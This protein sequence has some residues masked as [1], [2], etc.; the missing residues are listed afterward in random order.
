MYPFIQERKVII[1]AT[2]RSNSAVREREALG[3]LQGLRRLN[4][5]SF[6][7]SAHLSQPTWLTKPYLV[8][9]TRA[10]ALLIVI[11]DPE[12]LGKNKLWRTFLN[13]IILRGGRIGIKPDWNPRD[14]VRVAGY[15]IIPR[16]RPVYGEG[17]IDG[18]SENIYRYHGE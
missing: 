18:M 4:G 8:A 10:Q 7:F 11:G 1:F 13:Y 2:T 16:E 5:L 3:F 15:S 12:V 14:G 17:I 6:F 9:I